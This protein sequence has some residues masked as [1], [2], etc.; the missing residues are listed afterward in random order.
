MLTWSVHKLRDVGGLQG[1]CHGHLVSALY[2]PQMPPAGLFIWRMQCTVPHL[3]LKGFEVTAASRDLLRLQETQVR[4][5]AKQ[6]SSAEMRRAAQ[7]TSLLRAEW[8]THPV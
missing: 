3:G 1:P 2:K 5:P 7:C 8:Q 6:Q 4:M